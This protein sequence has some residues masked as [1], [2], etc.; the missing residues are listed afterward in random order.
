MISFN[1]IIHTTMQL[2]RAAHYAC[3]Y[4][5]I[6]ISLGINLIVAPCIS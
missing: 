3:M 1:Q 6:N 4:Q 5:C 2:L